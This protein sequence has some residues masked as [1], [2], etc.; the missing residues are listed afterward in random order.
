MNQSYLELIG[1]ISELDP[2]L[3]VFGG[4]AEDALLDHRLSRPHADVDVLVAR[5]RAWP[6]HEAV[7][8]PGLPRFR[9]KLRGDSR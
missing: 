9:S 1:A 4:V 6:T 8:S 5:E 7:R 3:F 2:P